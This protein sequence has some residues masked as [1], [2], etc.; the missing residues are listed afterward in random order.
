M[1]GR[2]LP[3]TDLHFPN[4]KGLPHQH[5]YYSTVQK[6]CTNSQD[7]LPLKSVLGPESRFIE[8]GSNRNPDLDPY[9]GFL[10]QQV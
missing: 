4:L 2:D 5:G 10:R 8:S 9:E 6:K 7:T 3:I 1:L